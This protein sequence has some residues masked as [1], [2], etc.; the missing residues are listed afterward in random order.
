MKKEIFS[1]L[2][3]IGVIFCLVS[4]LFA[5]YVSEEN[6][7]PFILPPTSPQASAS[8][9]DPNSLNALVNRE[10][11]N[12]FP[13]T[14]ISSFF[15]N[16][17]EKLNPSSP[18][19][20]TNLT[21]LNLNNLN[22]ERNL[23]LNDLNL[24]SSFDKT[25]KIDLKLGNNGLNLPFLT[26]TAL[27]IS[28]I[29]GALDLSQENNSQE[30]TILV[31]SLFPAQINEGEDERGEMDFVEEK[32]EKEEKEEEIPRE[33]SL[34]KEERSEISE[35]SKEE[36]KAP[37]PETPAFLKVN[38]PIPL[39]EINEINEINEASVNNNVKT[40]NM[41]VD[42]SSPVKEKERKTEAELLTASAQPLE[43]KVSPLPQMEKEGKNEAPEEK[44]IKPEDLEEVRNDPSTIINPEEIE[45]EFNR[46]KI[47]ALRTV[48][49]SAGKSGE[50]KEEK[51]NNSLP[52]EEVATRYTDFLREQLDK[53]VEKLKS[54]FSVKLEGEFIFNLL[55]LP[56]KKEDKE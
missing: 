33:L 23:S 27:N 46:A 16:A 53:L 1:L 40:V 20:F 34:T 35:I 54:P 37:P 39:G 50:K 28:T 48:L 3:G 44:M 56:P 24:S 15:S 9:F 55:K 26:L 42:D 8:P 49:R 29:L 36:E 30:N 12:F 18:S 47:I 14:E 2:V 7:T 45:A 6:N 38:N 32:E 52:T 31:T 41:A 4:S 43:I 11:N 5:F 19:Q 17:Q 21:D 22:N 51:V 13:N 25:E 10:K